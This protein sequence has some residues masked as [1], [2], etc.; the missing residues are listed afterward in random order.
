MGWPV[1]GGPVAP[2]AAGVSAEQQLDALNRQADRFADALDAVR[3]RIEQL[4]AQLRRDAE[5]SNG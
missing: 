3:K 1:A 2:F 5:R 4:Q